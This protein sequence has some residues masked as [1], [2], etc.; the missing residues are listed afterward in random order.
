MKV[1]ALFSSTAAVIAIATASNSTTNLPY[2]YEK[3]NTPTALDRN[4]RRWAHII[5]DGVGGTRTWPENSDGV[6]NIQFCFANDESRWELHKMLNQAW[7]L[8]TL[9]LG[10]SF[11]KESGH[12]LNFEEYHQVRT[13]GPNPGTYAFTCFKH[14]TSKCPTDDD[15][16]FE[17]KDKLSLDWNSEVPQD[18]LLV[19]LPNNYPGNLWSTYGYSTELAGN[20]LEFER[21][22]AV[23]V[24]A[25][26]VISLVSLVD[27]HKRLDRD[28][29]VHFNCKALKGYPEVQSVVDKSK[30]GPTIEELCSNQTLPRQYQE[31]VSWKDNPFASFNTDEYCKFAQDSRIFTGNY[32]V[33]SI[34]HVDSASNSID[35]CAS[36]KKREDC[37]LMRYSGPN[38]T[39]EGTSLE[40]IEAN[41]MPSDND[42]QNL[43]S[44]Y[45]WKKS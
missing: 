8:W 2:W 21:T 41:T 10:G 16:C 33:K 34:M 44:L 30:D 23:H 5:H 43:K 12:R 40:F 28:K 17:H 31:Q 13:E 38:Q 22:T 35:A 36:T 3:H 27:E 39:G 14:N 32:D 25:R 6:S 1:G 9:A 45:P 42:I 20:V 11:G 29:F 26:H 4:R 37:T 18:I 7:D 24:V 15:G 19:R